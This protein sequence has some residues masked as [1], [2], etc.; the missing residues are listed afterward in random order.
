MPEAMK[1]E[2]LDNE[3]IPEYFRKVEK[4]LRALSPEDQKLER[5]RRVVEA[6]QGVPVLFSG[7]SEKG[8]DEVVTNAE[9]CVK[10]GGFGFIYGRNMWKR[11]MQD[12]IS[13]SGK[14]IDIL[15]KA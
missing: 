6:A 15:D 14:L 9:I 1:E 10:A 13:M 2:D 8:D 5:T 12:A 3:A 11:E 4:E 7:G